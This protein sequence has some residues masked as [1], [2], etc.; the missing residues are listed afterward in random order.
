MRRMLRICIAVLVLA[1]GGTAMAAED[2]DLELV[3][4][5]DATGSITDSEITFQRQG[6]AQALTHP[7]VLGAINSGLHQRIVVT[8]VEWGDFTSQDVVVPWRV[9]D[10]ASSADAF[11]AELLGKPRRARG[12]N[13]IGQA[14]MLGKSLIE[15]NAFEA[16]RKVIDLSADSANNWNGIPLAQA[17]ASV[18]EAG[19]T[20][21]GLA[22]L[23]RAC[24]GR[25]VTYD[26]EQAFEDTIIGGPESFVITADDMQRFA[27]AV[28]NKLILEIAG[29]WNPG[30]AH[31]APDPDH[32][33]FKSGPVTWA[34]APYR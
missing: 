14:L 7:D 10:G 13:A 34:K 12:R 31:E 26:L 32:P 33:S 15:G 16:P 3:L 4:L 21:N 5:A 18:L 2:V 17:R 9:I 24:G 29:H 30:P 23:C 25:P 28:R 11:A 8:Y 27:I 1:S 19:M 6:Y 22:I 20:I